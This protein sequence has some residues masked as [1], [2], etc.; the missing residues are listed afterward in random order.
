LL[1]SP[2]FIVA[3]QQWRRSN[4]RSDGREGGGT[5][6]AMAAQQWRWRRIN[7]NGGAAMA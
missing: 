7:D 1:S 3:A 4:G 6:M 5:A 2:V